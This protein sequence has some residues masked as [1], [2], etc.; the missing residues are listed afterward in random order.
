MQQPLIK[1]ITTFLFLVAFLIPRIVDIH[2]F[3]HLS[4][5]DEPISCEL[6]DSI[7]HMQEFDLYFDFVTYDDDQILNRPSLF[8]IHTYY[9]SP[10]AKIATPTTI[11]NKPPPCALLG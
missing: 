6:C 1:H 4:D 10:I 9:N 11:Y 5:E 3:D 2:V 7:S 8:V